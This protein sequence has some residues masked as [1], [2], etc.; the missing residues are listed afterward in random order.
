MSTIDQSE[1]YEIKSEGDFISFVTEMLGR[2]DIDSNDFTFPRVVFQGWPKIEINVKGDPHRYNSSLTASMLFGMAELTHEIQKAFTVVSH[3][4]SNRQKLKDAEKG[5][6][7]I[8]Y[9]ISEGSS[10]ADGDS[11]PIVNGVV[12]VLT[13]A[14]GKMT[15]RQALCAVAAIVLASSTVGYEWINEYYKTQ[16]HDQDS[17]VELVEKSTKA[18]N[19]A[20]ENVLKLL[21]SGQTNISREVLAHGEDGKNK[22]LK[23]IA[24]DPSVEKVSVG[25][26][27]VNREQLNS[28]NQ[29]QSVDRKKETK[30]D[31]FYITG[32]RR[33][34]E[35]NQDINVDVIRVTNGESFTIKTS[36]DI[37]STEELLEFSGAVAKESVVE[38]SYLEV[39]EN[40]HISTGQLINIFPSNQ[41]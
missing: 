32:V 6:L 13:Q 20:H 19:E 11:D 35:T 18:V 21:V 27:I 34:G 17:Q 10:Q 26:R 36:S 12:T 3:S 9:R 1:L 4:T 38:L 24:Q 7:D 29:R 28:L 25:Q 16:R 41:K 22:L 40:G 37:T 39:V 2:K 23:K 5:L 8:V 15:G 33:S 30:T 31:R 14:I